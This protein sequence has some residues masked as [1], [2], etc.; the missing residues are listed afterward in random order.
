[1]S[2]QGVPLSMAMKL[3]ALI[4]LNLAL[5]LAGPEI[6]QYPPFLFPLVMLD[7]VLVQCVSLGRPLRAFHYTVLVVGLVAS[8]ALTWFTYVN[9]AP[10]QA[11]SLRIV[12]TA[13]VTFEDL[14][15]IPPWNRSDSFLE[16]L[17][18][19]ERCVTSALGVLLACVV[20]SCVAR[21]LSRRPPRTSSM[22][23]LLAS[24]FQ[25]ALIGLGVFTVIDLALEYSDLAPALAMRYLGLGLFI[26]GGG[27]SVPFLKRY[28]APASPG[29]E[30]ER[31]S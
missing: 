22:G 17:A 14:T 27:T 26:V 8:L 7:I 13:I 15:G 16:L 21:R 11:G 31:R 29:G 28:R 3:V 2:G 6:P 25:G 23:R 9:A 10:G 1:M 24:V 30:P 18:I 5:L 4:A 19:A 12:E 20:A